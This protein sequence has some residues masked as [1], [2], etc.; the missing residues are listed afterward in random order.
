MAPGSIVLGGLGAVGDLD[1]GGAVSG[2]GEP[3]DL[4]AGVLGSIYEASIRCVDRTPRIGCCGS[5]LG[6]GNRPKVCLG[7]PRVRGHVEPHEVGP[8]LGEVR[9][10]VIAQSPEIVAGA[11][12]IRPIEN[13]VLRRGSARRN[14][15]AECRGAR[16]QIDFNP[17]STSR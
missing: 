5:T 6:A 12:H 10:L 8:S 9:R 2:Q 15:F 13:L 7:C 17:L 3:V 4:S 14:L 16:P 1:R 11:G